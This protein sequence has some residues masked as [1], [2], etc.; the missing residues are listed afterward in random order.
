MHILLLQ[1][2]QL[3]KGLSHSYISGKILIAIT[4]EN[5]IAKAATSF[6]QDEVRLVKTANDI[7]SLKPDFVIHTRELWYS[8]ANVNKAEAWNSNAWS[9]IYLARAA[10]NVGAINVFL[11]SYMIFNGQKGAYTENSTPSPLNYYGLTKVVGEAVVASLGNY[12]IM[13]VG[14]VYG[15]N[16][17]GLFRPIIKNMVMGRRVV[18]N[19]NFF[20]SPIGIFG[21]GQATKLLIESKTRGIVNVAG[22]RSS[23]YA[24]CQKVGK[25]LGSQP[26][27]AEAGWADFSLENWL[28]KNLGYKVSLAYDME[29]SLSSFSEISKIRGALREESQG[30]SKCCN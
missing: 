5:P 19:Q 29:Q 20:L 3:I 23:M 15:Y 26:V 25:I 1:I 4:E 16:C 27:G 21:L 28:L 7:K 9:L 13:R 22:P 8:E 12:L 17:V 14:V 11:S 2:N 24:F 30:S 10:N 6:L 18:C